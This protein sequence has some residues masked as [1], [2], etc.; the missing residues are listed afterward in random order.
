MLSSP[1]WEGFG[2][3]LSAVSS[4]GRSHL[5][6]RLLVLIKRFANKSLQPDARI[7]FSP[8]LPFNSQSVAGSVNPSFPGLLGC[9]LVIC[10]LVN[11]AIESYHLSFGESIR[12]E[13]PTNERSTTN[14]YLGCAGL[15]FWLVSVFY[16]RPVSSVSSFGT[17]HI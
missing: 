11:S 17:C 8:I 1:F 2:V 14:W 3:L 7:L 15:H 12:R 9:P 13:L 4:F 10:E 16:F 6:S 5:Y